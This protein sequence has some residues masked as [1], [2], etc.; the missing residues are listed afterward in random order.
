MAETPELRWFGEYAKCPCGRD[1][2]GVLYGSRNQSYG[3][4]C[5]HCANKR[6]KASEAERARLELAQTLEPAR[7]ED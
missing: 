7:T 3:S 4:W 1:S 5:R 6:L 2:N